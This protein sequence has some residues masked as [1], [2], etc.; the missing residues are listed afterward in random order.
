MLLEVFHVLVEEDFVR[1]GELR[2]D[3]EQ[4]VAHLPLRDDEVQDQVGD[5]GED[6]AVGILG[7]FRGGLNN[8]KQIKAEKSKSLTSFLALKGSDLVQDLP[9]STNGSSLLFDTTCSSMEGITI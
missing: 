1:L 5:V 9:T 2:V 4:E 8:T 7:S 6:V 3:A